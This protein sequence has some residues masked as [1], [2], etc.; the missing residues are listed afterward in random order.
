MSSGTPARG[1]RNRYR[2]P[3]FHRFAL[4]L[5]AAIAF[6]SAI[7]AAPPPAVPGRIVVTLTEAGGRA[8]RQGGLRLPAP[9]GAASRAPHLVPLFTAASGPLARYA[10]LT[11]HPDPAD[12]ATPEAAAATWIE[13]IR[14]APEVTG[15]EPDRVLRMAALPDDPYFAGKDSLPAQFHLW[16]PGGL[17]LNAARAWPFVPAGREV[18]VGVLDSGLDWHHPDL[19]GPAPPGGR[20][21]VNAAEASGQ[22]GVDDDQNGFVDDVVGWDF[23][24]LTSAP[25][26]GA[27]PAPGEDA[28]TPDADPSDQAGHGTQVAGLVTAITGNGIG[29][30]GAAPAARIM[31]VRVGWLGTSGD[32]FVLMSFCAQG[33][34]YAARNGA[35]VLNCSWDSAN[36]DGLGAAVDEAIQA[37]DVVIVASAGNHG[38]TSTSIEYLGSRTDVLGVAGILESGVK[39]S[40]SNYGSWVEIAAFYRGMPSTQ[41]NRSTQTSTY[42][43]NS[44]GGTSFASPQVAAEAALLRAVAPGADAAAVR[45]AVVAGGRD[46]SDVEPDYASGLGGGLADFKAGV[47]AL[48]GGWDAATPA[49]GLTP[50]PDALGLAFLADSTLNLVA[51]DTGLPAPGWTGGMPRN[52]PKEVTLPPVVAHWETGAPAILVWADGPELRA[53]R[54]S[55]TSVPGWPVPLPAGASALVAAPLGT[56]G[57]AVFVPHGDDVL[58]LAAAPGGLVSRN[59]GAALTAIAISAPGADSTVLVAGVDTTGALVLLRDGPQGTGPVLPTGLAAGVPPMIGEFAAPGAPEVVVAAPDSLAPGSLQHVFFVEPTGTVALTVDL[60][61]PPIEALSLAGFA[62]GLRVAVVAVDTAG[63][64]HVIDRDGTVQSANAPGL[65]AGEVLCAD[66]DGD[67]ASDLLVLT[68]DGVLAGWNSDLLPL[69]GFPRTFPH[70]FTEPPVITGGGGARFVAVTDTAGTLWSLPLGSASRPDPWTA[71]GGGPGRARFLGFDR[72]TPV[73]PT[74]ALR[75]EGPAPGRVCW[76]GTGLDVFLRLRLLG[77]GESVW[78]GPPDDDGCAAVAVGDAGA[79]VR[80]EGRGRDGAWRRLAEIAIPG[81]E[82]PGLRAAVPSP[83][84]FRSE[85]RLSWSGARGP[86]RVEILDVR[87]RLVLARTL[88]GETG[89]FRWDGEDGAGVRTAPGI[90][91]LKLADGRA[92]AVRRV[93]RLP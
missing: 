18:V 81:P 30:A 40:Q 25:G 61:S 13:A 41:Y 93:L 76:E 6:P 73:A 44:V 36:L 56:G 52:V 57:D 85:T 34:E 69:P 50:D 28:T 71:A 79:T 31:P 16:N 12:G 29:L 4:S 83:N 92:T 33:I 47:Q 86:V 64:V 68:R 48:G 66:V 9:P 8:L 32:S 84:P 87:G 53:A 21:W 5:L 60:N 35:R 80:L 23:V 67:Y 45:N 51:G 82:A 17:S 20:L 74:A 37:Y 78:E 10:V 90:Y 39:A 59:L 46:L 43:V 65:V 2:R 91:F 11:F 3:R 75:W 1:I 63:G 89:G 38:D 55:G 88:A 15:A 62:S 27:N 77:T 54:E 58:V 49:R 26:G 19:A 72:A 42:I 22:D 70:G 7:H 24:H 14:A